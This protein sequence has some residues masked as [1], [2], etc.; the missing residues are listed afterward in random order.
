MRER[1][2]NLLDKLRMAQ[3]GA[4]EAVDAGNRGACAVAKTIGAQIDVLEYILGYN[5]TK[6]EEFVTFAKNAF[7]RPEFAGV[8]GGR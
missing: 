8:A 1:T 7:D 3:D 4:Y 5:G 2:L 6:S